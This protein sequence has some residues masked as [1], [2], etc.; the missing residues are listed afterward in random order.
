MGQ[1]FAE[2]NKKFKVTPMTNTNRND[3]KLTL[4][5]AIT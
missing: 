4:F 3:R 2:A 1:K 5:K